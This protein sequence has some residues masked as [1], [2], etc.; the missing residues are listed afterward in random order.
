VPLDL[1]INNGVGASTLTLTDLQLTALDINAGVGDLVV[2]L[3]ALESTYD[4][5]IDSGTGSTQVTI[6]DGAT[7]M[8]DINSGVGDVTI[9]V[10]EDAPVRLTRRGGLGSVSVP[11]WL[12]RIGEAT[13]GIDNDGTWESDS[14]AGADAPIT[15]EVDGGI[16]SLTVR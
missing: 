10:P 3:P 9:E 4:V 8:L 6:P 16:G 7:L 11:G 14:Y 13:D 5:S 15:I 1:E 12:D 2:M